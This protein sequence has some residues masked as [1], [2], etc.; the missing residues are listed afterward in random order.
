M[1]EAAMEDVGG[2]G[3]DL[4]YSSDDHVEYRGAQEGN[5]GLL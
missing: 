5:T 3:L 1:D 2:S 4:A